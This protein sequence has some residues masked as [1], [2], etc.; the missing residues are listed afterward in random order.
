MAE[1][2][3]IEGL[4]ELDEALKELPKAT[5]RNVLKR[6]LLE[7][8]VPIS[9]D[10]RAAAPDDPATSGFDLHTS[11]VEGTRLSRR[12]KRANKQESDVEVYVGAGPLPQAHLQEFGSARHS[13]QPFLR[14]AWDANVG[15]VLDT[16]ADKIRDEI[17]KARK[18]L[19]R[20]AE[21]EAAKMKA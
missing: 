21:R 15:P 14:P 18:R 17:E 19:A 3:K 1:H 5:A 6:V 7:S 13:A 11:V 2:F 20:K 9:R 4:A 12:Q 10:A 8:A 16:I